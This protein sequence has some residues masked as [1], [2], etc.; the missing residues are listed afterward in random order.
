MLLSDATYAK[1]A[2]AAG[3]TPLPDMHV[4]GHRAA[5]AVYALT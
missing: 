3:C 2:S 5:V 1:L 4:K